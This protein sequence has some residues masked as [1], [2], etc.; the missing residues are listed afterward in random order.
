MLPFGKIRLK[1]LRLPPWAFVPSTLGQHLKKRRLELGLLQ[2]EVAQRLAVD[3]FTYLTWEKDRKIPWDRYA[4]A[5]KAFLGYDPGPAPVSLP[6]RLKAKRRG[7]GLSR[8]AAARRLGIDEGTLYRWERGISEPKGRH[9][10]LIAQFIGGSN[11]SSES[12]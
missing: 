7:L 9:A 2:R 6:G 12:P 11:P 5:L 3:Q 1:S 10:E 8:K 4:P